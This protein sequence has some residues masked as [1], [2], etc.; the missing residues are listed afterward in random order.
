M[1]MGRTGEKGEG[2]LGGLIF[3]L[4]LAAVGLAAWH[5]VPVYF[6][7]YDYVDKVNEICRAPRHIT[8]RGGDETVMKMLMDEARRRRLDEWIGPESFKISTTDR[9]RRIDLYYE[10]E[11][12]V[13]P[14]WKK[15]FKFEYKADQPII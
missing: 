14:G 10:R 4:A 8:Q 6:D 3:L 5:V 11:V 7:H 2:K 1:T 15:T 13:L 12:E 9:G